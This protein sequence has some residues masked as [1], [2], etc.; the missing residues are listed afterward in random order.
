MGCRWLWPESVCRRFGCELINHLPASPFH[1]SLPLSGG[2]S[3]VY[4]RTLMRED[5]GTGTH[6]QSTES[7]GIK[8]AG[9]IS[10][11]ATLM[12]EA[13]NQNPSVGHRLSQCD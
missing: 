1:R 13:G 9:D 11:G 12:A 7:I 4:L 6:H 8:T 3:F 10:G 2:E 5:D